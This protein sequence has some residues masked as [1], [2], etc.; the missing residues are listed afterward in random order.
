MHFASAAHIKEVVEVYWLL[1]S[2]MH[3]S[4]QGLLPYSSVTSFGNNRIEYCKVHLAPPLK[5]MLTLSIW[6]SLQEACGIC[7]S[8][9]IPK[10]AKNLKPLEE[11]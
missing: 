8:L 2:S 4:L 1:F 9:A 11:H 10:T 7:E 5:P 6:P 3:C